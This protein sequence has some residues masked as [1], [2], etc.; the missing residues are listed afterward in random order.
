LSAVFVAQGEGGVVL[1]VIGTTAQP[2]FAFLGRKLQELS[3]F[4]RARHRE[5]RNALRYYA[6]LDFV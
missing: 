2:T 4:E 3:L 5:A 1:L 6:G